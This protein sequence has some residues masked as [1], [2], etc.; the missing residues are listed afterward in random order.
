MEVAEDHL[1]EAVD[2][3]EADRPVV[4][5]PARLLVV[6]RPVRPLVVDRLVAL[7]LVEVRPVEVGT[8]RP[9]GKFSRPG[10]LPKPARVR[11]RASIKERKA[12]DA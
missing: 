1:M 6:L 3:M 10:D 9:L 5:R 12:E 11:D 2:L 7:L 8:R 4:L